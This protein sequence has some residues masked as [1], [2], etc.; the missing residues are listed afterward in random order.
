MKLN[1]RQKL[2][3]PT[4][5]IILVCLSASGLVSYR[6]ARNALQTALR[7]QMNISATGIATQI[8]SYLG[9][10]QR[11]FKTLSGRNVVRDLLEAGTGASARQVDAANDA[12][13]QM[14]A[15]YPEQFEFLAI[16]DATG[17]AIAATDPAQIGTL[18]IHDRQYFQT[19]MQGSAAREL[20]QSRAT[21]QPA[22]IIAQPIQRD[23]QTVGVSLGA[24]KLT[25]IASHFI[26]PARIG[27]HGYAY[28]V[29]AG[30]RFLAHPQQENIFTKSI[31]DTDWGQ[32]ILRTK[33]GML[34]YAWQGVPKQV[35]FKE[36]S[37]TGWIVAA[38]AD[39]DDIFA[40]L[41]GIRW[42]SLLAG[43]FTLAGVGIGLYLV[44]DSIVK[45][46]RQGVAL[47]EDIMAGDVSRRLRL[48]RDDEIGTLAQ[49]L[50][51]MADGLEEKVQAA[52]K[53]AAGDLTIEV[54]LASERDV[55]GKALR[56]M[57]TDLNDLVTQLQLAGEQIAAGS[58]QVADGSQ[59]LSQGATESA[60]SLE[61]ISAAMAELASQTRHNADN[62][63]Q[64]NALSGSAQQNA[65]EGNRLMSDMVNAMAD[66]NHSADSITKIIKVIDEIA[67][68]T[69]LLA[70][71]AAV[72]AARAG[73]HGKGFA[74]VAEEV[75]NLAARS[76]KAAKETEELIEESGRRTARGAEIADKTAAALKDIV[77][78][79]AKVSDLVADIAA[80][81]KEQAAGLEEVS[82]GLGQIESVTQQ[83]TANAEESAA[84]AEELSGQAE[85]LRQM[86]RRFQVKSGR[87]H[88]S[89]ARTGSRQFDALPTLATA[90]GS[91][92]RP[93]RLAAPPDPAEVIALDDGEF[94]R[95]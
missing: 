65:S 45:A 44:S 79:A 87:Q 73:Q 37:N 82:K 14:L 4:A 84:A 85:H 92:G 32:E 29:D 86:L 77:T 47:A 80:A 26:A 59:T 19:A 11:T 48:N 63:L 35:V 83:T 81:S 71:N 10:L 61:E 23:G 43:L 78:G 31:G 28:L 18:R 69:N 53:I 15:D 33:S 6:S 74:V 57:V 50:D 27:D 62:A 94:G 67:F 88:R 64:A 20:V 5:L 90:N 1:L 51:R 9:D 46:L 66:I 36:V 2:L 21:G 41:A 39:F 16:T 54:Q 56:Q 68:Q 58:T 75:R 49:A 95:Y 40:P 72:E 42:V 30:G 24:V 13:L 76:A 89:S 22:L 3:L 52:Q 38:G 8:D 91:A 55:L 70:L 34:T 7:G 25:Y 17:T 60:A 12:L 93:A